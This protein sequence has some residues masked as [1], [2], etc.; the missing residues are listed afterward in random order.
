MK[1]KLEFKKHSISKL[2][3]YKIAGGTGGSSLDDETNQQPTHDCQ[4][5]QPQNGCRNTVDYPANCSADPTRCMV[6]PPTH[7]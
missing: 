3:S 2:N 4:T 1:R 6:D 5:Q 7:P